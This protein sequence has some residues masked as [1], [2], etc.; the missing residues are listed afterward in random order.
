[1]PSVCAG[2]LVDSAFNDY[3]ENLK[4]A[5]SSIARCPFVMRDL[6]YAPPLR[7]SGTYLDGLTTG[8]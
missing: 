3:P 7:R 5:V 2:R 4:L 1:M 6:H 8:K